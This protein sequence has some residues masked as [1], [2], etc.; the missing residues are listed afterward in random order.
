MKI[1]SNFASKEDNN[2]N[3]NN[4]NCVG[5]S[6]TSKLF[7]VSRITPSLFLSG[8]PAVREDVLV[9]LG[10][11]YVVSVA[12]ELPPPPLPPQVALVL[13]VP[14]KDLPSEDLLSRLH[15]TTDTIQQ[16]IEGGG[17]VLVHCVAGVSRSA[18]IVLAYLVKHQRL[19]L[20]DAFTHLRACRPAVRPN[21]GFFRQLIE[22]EQQ[23]M[24]TTSVDMVFNSA[25][26]THI[27]DVYEPDYQNTLCFLNNRNFGKH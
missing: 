9:S 23:T 18:A 8:A 19:P 4:D 20:H 22:F 10:V 12:P 24:G 5:D 17:R 14:L 21:T 7:C 2:N 3:N 11:S 6:P 15:T 16:V 26:R 27:P 13:R 1:L 25:A